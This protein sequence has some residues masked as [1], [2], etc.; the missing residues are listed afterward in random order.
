MRFDLETRASP[1]QV[2]RALTDFSDARLRTWNRSLD[3]WSYRLLD[4]GDHWAV[5][6][7]S[8]SGSPFWVVLRYDW[9]D[10]DVVRW[11]VTDS[12]YGG[13]GHGLVRVTAAPDGGSRV[14]AEWDN[15]D[16]R[17]QKWLLFLIRHGPMDRF[18]S[19]LWTSQLD[20]YAVEASSDG[21]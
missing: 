17:R 1:E 21:G 7:E 11:T 6:R 10:P 15:A 20:R 18:V 8:T 9:S 14:H 2:R 12:S 19:R 5:A 3:P 16:A 4:E 13:S